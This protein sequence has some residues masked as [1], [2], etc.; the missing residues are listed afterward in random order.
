MQTAT[1]FAIKCIISSKTKFYYWV[2]FFS[3]DNAEQLADLICS[4][5][6]SEPYETLKGCLFDLYELNS[7][8]CFESFSCLPFSADMKPSHLMSKMQYLLPKDHKPVFFIH[9]HFLLGFPTGISH[10]V[11]EDIKYPSALARKA[12]ELWQNS[13]LAAL[14][15]LS[16]SSDDQEVKDVLLFPPVCFPFSFPC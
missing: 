2:A 5:P 3:K 12:D 8:Q 6:S 16:Y 4:P 13:Y 10:L 9:W 15:K 14:N 11:Q 7:L 1:H